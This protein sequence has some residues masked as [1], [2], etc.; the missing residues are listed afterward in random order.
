MK[1]LTYNILCKRIRNGGTERALSEEPQTITVG[2]LASAVTEAGGIRCTPRMIRNY[3]SRGLIAEPVRSS[4][5][6]RLYA[7]E[8]IERIVRIKKLQGE[9]DL[10]LAAINHLLGMGDGNR[11]PPETSPLLANGISTRRAPLLTGEESRRARLVKAAD[12]VLRAKGYGETTIEDIVS[13]AGVAKGTFYL[14]FNNKQEL[15]L[16]VLRMAVQDLEEH[17]EEALDGVAGPVDRFKR[18]ALSYMRGYLNYRDLILILHG[19]AVGGNTRFQRELRS[20]YESLTSTLSEDVNE[21]ASRFK[22]PA[23]NT[24]LLSYALIGAGEMLAYRSTLDDRYNL[25][26]IVTQAM[27]LISGEAAESPYTGS[28]N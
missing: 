19:E 5:G 26:E 9:Y 28:E 23:I 22:S 15:F 10:S 2:K 4:G 18:R 14:Y 16:E 21:V 11:P 25:E 12:S 27:G 7:V 17:L 13:E 20:I 1:R 24:E 3:E 6:I 8:E